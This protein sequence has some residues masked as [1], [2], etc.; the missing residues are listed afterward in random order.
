MSQFKA[1]TIRIAL[2]KMLNGSGHFSICDLDKLGSLLG[3]NP[4]THP[5][6]RIL[7]ALHCVN[8][9]EMSAEMKA[10]L[11][12]KIMGVLSASFD[13]DLMAK[14]L[15]AVSSGEV[16]NLPPIEDVEVSKT[17]LIKLFKS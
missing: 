13:T 7:N 8:Y 16:K 9:T 4:K 17:K 10:E 1:E 6:Y 15:I 3:T 14:A 12:G 11:P 5:D 2:D